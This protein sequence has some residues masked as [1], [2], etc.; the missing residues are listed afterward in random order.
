MEMLPSPQPPDRADRIGWLEARLAR[1]RALSLLQSGRLSI[2]RHRVTS[3]ADGDCCQSFRVWR[4]RIRGAARLAQTPEEGRKR[5]L[6]R[7]WS[8]WRLSTLDYALP[9]RCRHRPSSF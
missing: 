6:V 9:Q 8:M 5:A 3:P 4:A 2:A 1:Y 7:R